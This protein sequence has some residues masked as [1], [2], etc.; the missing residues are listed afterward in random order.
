MASSKKLA[1]KKIEDL[2]IFSGS[3]NRPLAQ[4]VA[5]LL[6]IDLSPLTITHLADSEIHVQIGELVRAQDVFIIQPCGMPVN[7]NLVELLLLLDAFRRASARAINVVIPY[8]PYARQDRMARGREAISAKVVARAIESGG[9]SRVIY[10]DI[11]ALQIQGFFDIPVD[12]LT[13]LP[14]LADYFQNDSRFANAVIVSPD[15][16]RARLA[17][18]YAGQLGLPLVIMHKH[19]FNFEGTK[20]LA[21]VGDIQGKTPILIDDL[22]AGG[23]VLDQIPALLK[24]GAEPP[25]YLSITHPILLPSALERLNRDEIAE[26]VTTDTLCLPPEKQHPKVKVQTI[27]P[28]LAESILRIHEG[29][30]ISPL[31][32]LL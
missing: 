26:L 4:A 24:A 2:R 21:V 20:T 10:V 23:S 18:N 29:Q 12:P 11:H 27:A 9:A 31:L 7:D 3:A 28:L 30:T 32:R 16:G 5:A 17:S 6:G 15:V 1:D 25:V 13:A 8:F 22:I 14:V 19:R